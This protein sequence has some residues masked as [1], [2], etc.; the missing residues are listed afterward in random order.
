MPH[1][2][3][4]LERQM[5]HS[6][7]LL[8][9]QVSTSDAN[10]L[11]GALS[12]K[13]LERVVYKNEFHMLEIKFGFNGFERFNGL[14]TFICE[15]F[16]TEKVYEK[17]YTEYD[18]IYKFSIYSCI[19]EN[20]IMNEQP[21]I[22]FNNDV[23]VSWNYKSRSNK[24]KTITF[25]LEEK[26]KYTSEEIINLRKENTFLTKKIHTLEEELKNMQEGVIK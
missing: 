23:N 1:S 22:I 9:R 25:S 12:A 20:I 2:S 6:S 16:I 7:E 5:P 13:P 15:N 24:I 14:Y 10:N 18:L 21:K 8:E 19:F 4:L 11:R 26:T 17:T 3:E